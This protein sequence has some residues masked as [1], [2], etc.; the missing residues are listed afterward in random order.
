MKIAVLSGKGGTGKTFVSVNLAAVAANTAY[1]DCDAEEPNGYLFLKPEEEQTE[2]VYTTVPVF[3][4]HTCDGCR[5]C[6]DFCHFNALAFVKGR[7]K[8]FPEICHACG[9]CTLVCP[10]GAVTE[11]KRAIGTVSQGVSN[12]IPIVTA[13][14]NLGEASAV[15]II[16]A[17]VQKAGDNAVIDS[18][19]GSGC[20]VT[21]SV[22]GADYCLL[23]A[24]PTAFGLHNL[25][26][27]HE[28]VTLLHKPYGVIVN[29]SNGI[30][31]PL[32]DYCGKN[33]IPILLR[34]QY[35]K[36]IAKI[37]AGGAL[38][39]NHSAEMRRLFEILWET[40]SQQVEQ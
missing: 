28:L 37:S 22:S 36:K 17:A 21:E 32:E 11:E 7:P 38:A 24:E 26:M 2:I 25:R 20:P 4:A 18:S 23:V 19:P 27:V 29:K 39:V 13:A 30:Y 34:I 16:R 9:G 1:I 40:T 12:G 8:V 3:D 33:R 5:K 31:Q 10:R 35:S 14:L 6:V 15:P